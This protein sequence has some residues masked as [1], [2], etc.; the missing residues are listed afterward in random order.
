MFEE[1]LAT[2]ALLKPTVYIHISTHIPSK[3]QNRDGDLEDSFFV[4]DYDG[5]NVVLTN[6][7]YAATIGSEL[8]K[9][10]NVIWGLP[11]YKIDFP[12]RLEMRYP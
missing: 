5:E 9:V 11:E 8:E 3:A 12:L 7:E 4:V 6:P 10:Y 2:Y 1:L